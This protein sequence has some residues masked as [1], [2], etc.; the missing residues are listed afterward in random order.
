MIPDP[1]QYL[2]YFA[3]RTTRIDFG[4]MI[5]VLPWHNP[6]RVAENVAVLQHMMG[7]G[8]RYYMGVGRGLAFRNFKAMGVKMDDSRGRFNEALDILELAL[9]QDLFSY[10]GEF[11]E[12]DNVAVRPRPFDRDAITI[13]GTWTSEQSLRNMAERGLQPLT[14][15]SKKLTSYME[16]LQ[17]FNEIREQAG[18]GPGDRPVLQ[19]MLACCQSEQEAR[20]H[21]EGYFREL[22]DSI[23][24]MYE[25]D[26][27]KDRMARTKGYEQYIS[28]GSDFGSGTYED[29]VDSLTAK[30]VDEGIVGTP[31]QCLEKVIS[32]Y[33]TINPSELVVVNCAGG[34]PGDVSQ[35]NMRLFAEAVMPRAAQHI[36]SLTAV[37]P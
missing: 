21:A 29:A 9:T 33:E 34:M 25:I 31:E 11:F 10:E 32:H 14:N 6:V 30:F 19:V 2:T 3:S 28:Q 12:Y 16:E 24:R 22:V 7:R 23:L 36:R 4:S 13:L 20:E 5:V 27:W 1:H 15:P 35:R 17:L 18:F 8:R 37:T 26:Q